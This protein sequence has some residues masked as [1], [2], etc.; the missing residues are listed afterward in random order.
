MTT[1]ELQSATDALIRY[2]ILLQRVAQL[3]ILKDT[4]QDAKEPQ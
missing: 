4:P 2:A 3:G 1:A